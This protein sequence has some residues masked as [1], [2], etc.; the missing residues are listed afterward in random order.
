MRICRFHATYLSY[1][2]YVKCHI[3]FTNRKIQRTPVKVPSE[4][5]YYITIYQFIRPNRRI[6]M[7]KPISTAI[8]TLIQEIGDLPAILPV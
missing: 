6:R 5:H 3:L 7:A 1:G 8:M 2:E 4:I